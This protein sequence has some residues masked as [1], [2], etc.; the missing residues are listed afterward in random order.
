MVTSFIPAVVRPGSS[1]LELGEWARLRPGT[2]DGAM[3]CSDGQ[4]SPEPS[5]LLQ[6]GIFGFDNRD[7]RSRAF[8]MLRQH[9]L[10]G[11]YAEG[12]RTIAILSARPGEGKTFV[13]I[14][15]AASL[16][17]IMPT[18][19]IELD[20]CRPSISER[21]GLRCQAGVDDFLSGTVEGGKVAYRLTDT[22]LTVLP[23][24]APV[25]NSF[26]SLDSNRLTELFSALRS[27]AD[28]P[29]CI[30][31]CPPVIALDDILY[32]LKHIDGVL[33]VVEEGQTRRSE[34]EEA[35]SIFGSTPVV[36]TVLN[37]SLAG[38][39]PRRDDYY[40]DRS[41]PSREN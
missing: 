2:A 15:L 3:I 8:V 25:P 4:F 30:V 33:L 10:K 20:L 39:M 7:P 28:G 24:R 1:E 34:V 40:Y 23:V 38:R 19:L 9:L 36:G 17:R 31:D 21:L 6:H 11:F 16:S 35:L 18:I 27:S 22:D 14:N 41:V 37:K 13:A 29:L 5:V 32:V 26:R 12:G